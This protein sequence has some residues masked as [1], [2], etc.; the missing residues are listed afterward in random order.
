MKVLSVLRMIGFIGTALTS[1]PL[2][3]FYVS[4][5][6]PKN[7]MLVHLHVWLG[8]MFIVFAVSSMIINKRAKN[9]NS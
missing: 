6:E 3:F 8:L 7:H 9:K 5:Q 4:N 2:F 1:I